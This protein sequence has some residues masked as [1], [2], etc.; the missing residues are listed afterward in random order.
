ML[1]QQTPQG[2]PTTRELTE[3]CTG[4]GADVVTDLVDGGLH[5]ATCGQW[6]FLCGECM[7]RISEHA[8]ESAWLCPECREDARFGTH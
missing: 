3:A 2:A 6:H 7:P 5:C 4:C 1:G 8:R